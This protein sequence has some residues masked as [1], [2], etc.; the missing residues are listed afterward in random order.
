MVDMASEGL[1]RVVIAPLEICITRSTPWPLS[2]VS[3]AIPAR[4]IR[5]DGFNPNEE[6]GYRYPAPVVVRIAKFSCF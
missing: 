5:L 1:A 4:R 6:A 2:N 3:M